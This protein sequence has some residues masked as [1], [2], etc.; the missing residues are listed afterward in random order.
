MCVCICLCDHG[1]GGTVQRLGQNGGD[2]F[3]ASP[4]FAKRIGSDL[5]IPTFAFYR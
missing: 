3:R 5:R 1:V 4:A 2:G